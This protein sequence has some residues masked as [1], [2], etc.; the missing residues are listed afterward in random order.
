MHN[1]VVTGSKSSIVTRYKSLHP[2]VN[3]I[4][5]RCEN[6]KGDLL[7]EPRFL[8]CQGLLY[9]K[10]KQNQTKLEQYNSKDT[11]YISIVHAV[12]KIMDTNPIARI[13]ILGSESGY[14][15]SYDE[16]YA[17]SKRLLHE[18][19]CNMPLRH[20]GQQLVGIS[21]WIIEDTSMT[22]AR[23]D[24]ANLHNKRQS[25]PKKRFLKAIEV[26][27]LIHTLLFEQSYISNTVVRM[28]GGLQ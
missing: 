27:Q 4:P 19:I 17:E 16:S 14:R 9:S 11:N 13:C 6:I 8:F 5:T 2:E 21:P 10:T 18:F 22:E 3:I 28:H 7:N 15:G 20:P 24:I 23:T 26:S 12:T 1:I 25:H